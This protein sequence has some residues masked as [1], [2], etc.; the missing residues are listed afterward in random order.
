MFAFDDLRRLLVE[1]VGVED[2]KI[3]NDPSLTFTDMGVESLGFV[4]LMLAMQ[5]EL[6]FTI[7]EEDAEKILTIGDVLAYANRRL[8]EPRGA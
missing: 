5:Q 1:R 8:A 7:P 4:E 2:D 6:G 3:V